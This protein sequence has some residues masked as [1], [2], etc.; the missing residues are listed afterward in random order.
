[1]NFYIN[2]INEKS[3][4]TLRNINAIKEYNQYILLNKTKNYDKKHYFAFQVPEKL[5]HK[6]EEY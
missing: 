3:N 2:K 1:M 6:P 5:N 4:E